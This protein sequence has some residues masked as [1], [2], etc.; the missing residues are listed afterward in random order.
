MDKEQLRREMLRLRG[1]ER[2]GAEAERACLRRLTE[3]PEFLGAGTLFCYAAYGS[4]LPTGRIASYW[5]Q[6]GKRLAYP[7]VL[8]DRRMAFYAAGKLE[9]GYRGIPEPSGG[10]EVLPA[11]GDFMLLPGLAFS[12]QGD[13][14]GYG[15]GYY[16]R[17]LSTLGFRPVC[18]GIGYERQ[19]VATLP[20]DPLDQRLDL[21]ITPEKLYRFVH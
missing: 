21:L 20:C 4:E 12:R 18:C 15:R 14:L 7:R 8:D 5:A 2:G 1:G 19:L 16:D 17:Y 9:P 3:V 10:V 6:T 13:R 11:P